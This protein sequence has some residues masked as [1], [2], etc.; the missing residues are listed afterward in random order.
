VNKIIGKTTI[1][2]LLF[3]SGKFCGYIAWALLV[4]SLFSIADIRQIN[5]QGWVAVIILCVSLIFII[6]SLINLGNSTRLGIPKENTEFK[7]NGLYKISR[8]PMYVGFNMLSLSAI[9]FTSNFVVLYLGIYSICVYHLII[10]G[11]EKF[12]ENRFSE[13]Y[14]EYKKNVRRYL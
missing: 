10:L 5:P 2:P 7:T 9:L 1:S 11:E 8:N 3:Y 13:E 6:I 4:K 14:L 12:L